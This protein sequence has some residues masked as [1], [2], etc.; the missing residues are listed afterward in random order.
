MSVKTDSLAGAFV[1]CDSDKPWRLFAA[2]GALVRTWFLKP[3]LPSDDSTNSPTEFITTAVGT[4]PLTV[5][6][7]TGYPLLATTGGTEYN[8]LNFQ[9][10]GESCKLV[11]GKTAYLRGKVKLSEATQIDFLLGLCELKTDLMK[12]SVAHGVLATGVEGVFF[13]K[14]DGSTTIKFKAYKD[15]AETFTCDVGVLGTVDM[16][17]EIV[18]D[19]SAVKVYLDGILITQFSGTLPDGDLTPS[20]NLRSGD[21]N[22]RTESFAELSYVSIG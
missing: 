2:F 12:T 10:R 21:G 11:S 1:L 20:F 8:G 22:A 18:W 6:E 15:G 19:G 13:V 9:L 4:S 5:G 14:V 16:D 7:V 3:G 17:Y